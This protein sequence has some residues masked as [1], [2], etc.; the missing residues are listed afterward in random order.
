M[1]HHTRF[2]TDVSTIEIAV[3]CISART[4]AGVQML[5][6]A[7]FDEYEQQP[8]WFVS[9][10]EMLDAA[11]AKPAAPDRLIHQLTSD[12]ASDCCSPVLVGDTTHLF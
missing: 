2:A 5:N 10:N 1:K 4:I 6:A 12:L 7:R 3:C 11:A 9:R 8:D